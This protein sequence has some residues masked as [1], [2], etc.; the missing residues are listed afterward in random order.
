MADIKTCPFCLEEIPARAIKCRYCES[1][2]DEVPAKASEEYT[3][4]RPAYGGEE[5]GAGAGYG[6][7]YDEVPEQKKSKKFLVPLVIIA[8]V[9][10]LAGAGAGYW[11]LLDENGTPVAEA[12]E[13]DDIL[14]S[15]KGTTG[16]EEIY[17]QFQPNDMVSIAV[18]SE[19]YWFRTEYRL[20]A[21]GDKSYLELHHRGTDEWERIAELTAAEPDTIVMTDT[22]DGIVIDL[23]NYPDAEVGDVFRE[24]RFER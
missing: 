17:F 15:W 4:G 7:D 5:T 11:F 10:L 1:I 21:S 20:V 18:P 14:G 13:R 6:M 23:I 9:L 3:S 16:A 12:V 22:W 19:G 2:V 24:L 8:A